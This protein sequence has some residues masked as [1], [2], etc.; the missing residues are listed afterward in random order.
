M[1]RIKPA[2]ELDE[3]CAGGAYVGSRVI[4]GAGFVASGEAEVMALKNRELTVDLHTRLIS[5]HEHTAYSM[6]DTLFIPC[7]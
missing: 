1:H 4:G 3:H 5:T 6:S 7:G 2:V